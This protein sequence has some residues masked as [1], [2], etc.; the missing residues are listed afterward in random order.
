LEVKVKIQF[1]W[2]TNWDL[3]DNGSI[4]DEVDPTYLDGKFVGL[5]QA[6]EA[7]SVDELICEGLV[8]IYK[9]VEVNHG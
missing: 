6:T 2:L 9:M 4:D 8:G 7:H 3:T 5:P 1:V